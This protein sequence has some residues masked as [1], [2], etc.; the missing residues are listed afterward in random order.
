MWEAYLKYGHPNVLLIALS[1]LGFFLVVRELSTSL[2]QYLKQ[3]EN[4]MFIT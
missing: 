4:L 1:K 2:F 3:Q